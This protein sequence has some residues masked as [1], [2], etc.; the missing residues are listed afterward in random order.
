MTE[1]GSHDPLIGCRQPS[2]RH[3]CEEGAGL[4]DEGTERGKWAGQKSAQGRAKRGA[5]LTRRQVENDRQGRHRSCGGPHPLVLAGQFGVVFLVVGWA[6]RCVRFIGR[7]RMIGG[8]WSGLLSFATTA[9]AAGG[10]VVTPSEG[11]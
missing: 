3:R 10:V 4:N 2:A 1:R 7:K 6:A 9:L 8:P 5:L 11:R